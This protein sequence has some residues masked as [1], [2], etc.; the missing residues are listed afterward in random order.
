MVL[1]IFAWV[2][3]Q[4]LQHRSPVRPTWARRVCTSAQ[5]P[6][7]TRSANSSYSVFA[8]AAPSPTARSAPGRAQ[9]GTVPFTTQ[10]VAAYERGPSA[11]P[12]R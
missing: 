1:R 10:E 9:N 2:I 8:K 6:S 7:S 12:S 4:T 3:A 11:S 5:R